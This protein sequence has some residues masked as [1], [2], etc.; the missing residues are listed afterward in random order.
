MTPTQADREA[1]A[2]L[3]EA[4]PALSSSHDAALKTAQ[5]IRDGGGDGWNT[6]QMFT[7]HRLAAEAAA[8]EKAAGV[9]LREVR[10]EGNGAAVK[11]N[12][13]IIYQD[14]RKLAGEK[15]D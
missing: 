1:A 8:F 4:F 13:G 3:Y 2:A 7:R 12:A 11:A 6:V 5:F 10:D 15:H 14:I 9:A